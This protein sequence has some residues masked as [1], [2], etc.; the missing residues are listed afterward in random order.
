[1]GK[2]ARAILPG[3]LALGLVFGVPSAQAAAGSLD[4]TFGKGGIVETNFASYVN[5]SPLAAALQCNGDIL[6]L[7]Q[8]GNGTAAVVRYTPTGALDTTFRT[9]GIAELPTPFDGPTGSMALQSNGQIVVAG[10][11][12]RTTGEAAF[13]VARFNTNGTVD[14]TI[15]SG[16][17]VSTPL[18][19][20]G[21]GESVLIEPDGAILVGAQLEPAGRGLPFKLH[22]TYPRK[23][24]SEVV[25]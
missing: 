7:V 23:I 1:M 14:T 20:P 15:G 13:A 8:F 6:V 10:V 17:E 5:V 11:V 22:R 18:G 2:H 3:L 12:G 9:K 16:G 21:V 4:T 24:F 19:F 25:Y